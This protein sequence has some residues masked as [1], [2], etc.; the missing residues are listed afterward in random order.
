[1]VD[2][3]KICDLIPITQ[4]IYFVGKVLI[5]ILNLTSAP[6]KHC[7]VLDYIISFYHIFTYVVTSQVNVVK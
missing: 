1:M 7:N 6:K 4:K 3:I 5:I 2:F